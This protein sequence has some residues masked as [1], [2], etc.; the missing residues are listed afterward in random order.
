MGTTVMAVTVA[1]RSLE[2][3]LMILEPGGQY[4]WKDKTFTRL[5]IVEA[6]DTHQG[7][8]PTSFSPYDM[9]V[10]KP[11]AKAYTDDPDEPE[12]TGISKSR[13]TSS[14]K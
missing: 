11:T 14:I 6:D 12:G 4:H 10:E 1:V 7:T 13:S 3:F 8:K 2:I 5:A 9:I